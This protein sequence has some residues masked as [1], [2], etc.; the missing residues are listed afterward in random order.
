MTITPDKIPSQ[1]QES[2]PALETEMQPK[3]EYDNPNYKGSDKLK[4]KVALITGGDSG[5]G[6]SVAVF[7]AKEGADVAIVYFDEHKDAEETKKSVESYGRRCLL[8]PGDIRN[9]TFCH[10]AVNKTVEE[11]GR[12]DILVNNAAVQY[13]EPSF[14]EIDSARLGNIFAID[15]FAM[16]YF[17]RAAEPHLKAESSIINTTSINAYKGNATLLSYST[18]KG[19]ILAFTRSIA[20]P[21]LEQG[22][23]VNGVAPGPIWT[24][25]IP[26]AFP[27]DTVKDFGKQEHKAR[28]NFP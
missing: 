10:E 24:P 7:Y 21:M 3:P 19:A 13:L 23:R 14:D 20:Q 4:D 8:I 25:F 28:G 27:A 18:T 2:P 22:I 26:D 11:F 5:I 1:S 15:V 17:T 12:L 6:R 9:E 16:F